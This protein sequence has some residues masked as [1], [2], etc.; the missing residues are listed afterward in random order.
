MGITPRKDEVEGVVSLLESDEFDDAGE[1]AKAIIKLVADV[2]SQRT[3]H[4]V[5][6]GMPGCKPAL[7]IGPLYTIRDAQRVAKDAQQ[8]GLEARIRRLSGTAS[9]KAALVLRTLCTCGHRTESHVWTTC[10]IADC[11]CESVNFEEGNL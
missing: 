11:G 4:G 10:T 9:I 1:M 8:C 3:T 5:A 2:L 6:V 7:A